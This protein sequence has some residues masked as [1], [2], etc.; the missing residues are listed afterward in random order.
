MIYQLQLDVELFV[1]VHRK[2][3]SRLLLYLKIL[4]SYLSISFNYTMHFFKATDHCHIH[5]L[6]GWAFHPNKISFTPTN[7]LSCHIPSHHCCMVTLD[8]NIVTF[9][10]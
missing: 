9:S 5:N 3:S 4:S 2:G 1:N 6:K 8:L 10:F 7:H